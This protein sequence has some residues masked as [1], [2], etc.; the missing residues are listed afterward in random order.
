M[1]MLKQLSL[2]ALMY[3]FLLSTGNTVNAQIVPDRSLPT[4]SVVNVNG[5]TSTI[6]QGTRQDKNVFHSFESFSIP[7]G[8]TARFQTS[9]EVNNIF[10]RV[11]GVNISQINGLLGSSGSANL[12]FLNSNGVV[13]GRGASIDIGGSFLASTSDRIDF[14]NGLSFNSLGSVEI[15]KLSVQN[16]I[17]LSFRNASDIEVRSDG[18]DLRTVPMINAPIGLGE[19]NTGLRSSDGQSISLLG[20]NVLFDAGV[21][22]APSGNINIASVK[23]GIIGLNGQGFEGF[24]FSNVQ[25]F[26]DASFRNTSLIDATGIADQSISISAKDINISDNSLVISGN[27]GENSTSSISLNAQNSFSISNIE[28]PLNLLRFVNEDFYI[29]GGVVSVGF[30]T[31][32]GPD[33]NISAK[34][35]DI[36]NAG[37]ISSVTFGPGEGGSIGIDVEDSIEVS[38]TEIFPD[39]LGNG[40]T[41]SAIIAATVGGLGGDIDISTSDLKVLGGGNIATQV[42]SASRGGDITINAENVVV[43]GGLIIDPETNTV[44]GSSIGGFSA[45]SGNLGDVELNTET[46][47]LI[48]GGRITS[49][50]GSVGNSGS[51]FVLATDSIEIGGEVSGSE[52]GINS[53]ST[54]NAAIE[55]F[56]P[57][58]QDFFA[59]PPVPVGDAG[60]VS[61]ETNSLKVFDGGSIAVTNE[62]TG[63]GGEIF[64]QASS[65]NLEQQSSI[66]A[67]AASGRGGNIN[68]NAEL[69]QLSGAS[70]ISSTASGFGAGGNIFLNSDILIIE[71]SFISADAEQASGGSIIID[72]DVI[73]KT[74]SSIISA[75]S[76]LGAPFNGIVSITTPNVDLLRAATD[77]EL[78]PDVPKIAVVC[79]RTGEESE[80]TMAGSA[81]LP[82]ASTDYT[83]S[84]LKFYEQGKPADKPLMI[85]DPVTGEKEEFKR[86]VGWK[87]NPDGKTVRLVS[88]PNE[89]IQFQAARTACLKN[90]ITS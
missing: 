57:F 79:N 49:V 16:P 44:V 15:G 43:S 80:L 50:P 11:T 10:S 76:Q 35:I 60:T 20:G 34:S 32:S 62:G 47:Q 14:P 24:D 70:Q 45:A 55:R 89:A 29:F 4:K 73:F 28:N 58:L 25:S 23:D 41:P 71:D 33:I 90:P 82:V 64:V 56:N 75:S 48:D 83:D 7:N 5:N 54:I 74:P 53:S 84:R 66:A 17:S 27:I 87:L 30:S 72:S 59:L 22:T 3:G 31:G 68:V 52:G 18:H 12:Y 6:T 26:G 69:T 39:I 86:F 85:T 9:P 8:Q 65:I 1:S 51:I 78:P 2:V 37:V 21:L 81:G 38:T 63:V 67:I 46:L 40:F 36:E 88:D 19:S 61:L 13:F 42:A 77:V